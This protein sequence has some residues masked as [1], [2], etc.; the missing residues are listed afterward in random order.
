MQ[1]SGEHPPWPERSWRDGVVR[2]SVRVVAY[3]RGLPRWV[4]AAVVAVIFL[5]GLA[6]PGPAGAAALLA[7][8][9]LLCWLLV[10]SWPVLAPAGRALRV[11]ALVLLVVVAGASLNRHW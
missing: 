7:V 10:L 11:L 8:A 4:P 5:T 2:R 3:L 6:M 9:A 1:T